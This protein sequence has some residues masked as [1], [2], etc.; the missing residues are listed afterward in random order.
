MRE[1]NLKLIRLPFEAAGILFQNEGD[2][3]AAD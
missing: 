3:S 2:C 1:S